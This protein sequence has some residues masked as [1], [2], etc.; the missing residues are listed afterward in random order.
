MMFEM[1]NKQIASEA[2]CLNGGSN[3][4]LYFCLLIVVVCSKYVFEYKFCKYLLINI[5]KLS[6]I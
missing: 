6:K 3:V 5:F 2:I 4:G 1:M